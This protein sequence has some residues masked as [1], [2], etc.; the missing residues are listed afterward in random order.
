[1]DLNADSEWQKDSKAFISSFFSAIKQFL[2][3]L[4]RTCMALKKFKNEYAN[5]LQKT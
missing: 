4:C 3:F 5:K 2:A 1:M